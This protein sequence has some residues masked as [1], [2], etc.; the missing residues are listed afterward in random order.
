MV[1]AAALGVGRPGERIA[2]SHDTSNDTIAATVRVAGR[3]FGLLEPGE[4]DWL[5]THWGIALQAF[6]SE[7]TPVVGLRWAEWAAPAGMDEHRAWI[8]EHLAAQPLDGARL[9]YEDLLRDAGSTAVRHETLVTVTVH[10]GRVRRRRNT[11]RVAEAVETL[12]KEMRLF[13]HRL[14]GAG[15]IVSATLSPAEWSRVVRLRLDPASRTALDGRLRSLGD[16]DGACTPA[17]A[18]P[19][20]AETTWTAWHTDGAWHRA[21]YVSDWPRLDVHATW[22]RDLLLFAGSVRTVAVF[23]EPVARSK[24]QRSIVRDAAKIE[25]DAA[26]RAE[27]GFRVG[28]HHR[29]ARQAVE[30]REEELVA[31]YGEFSYAGIVTVTAADLDELDSVTNDIT[32]VAA[33]IGLDLR[34]L[35]GRHDLA[36]A[37]TLPIARGLIPKDW[38]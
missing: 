35:H 4:Q 24:S 19:L 37:A 8:S 36:V 27:K 6:V 1:D 31:G 7:R 11:D 34:P 21:L 2:V 23:M 20:A 25:S 12:L 14:Q 32:Q 17:N 38:L 5:V 9:A 30:E 3:Q 26:H 33:S 29:R 15:L 28:A 16:T 10:I 13:G 22:L 18:A